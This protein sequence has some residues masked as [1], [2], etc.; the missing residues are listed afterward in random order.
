MRKTVVPK[1]NLSTFIYARNI[2]KSGAQGNEMNLVIGITARREPRF[3]TAQAK[4]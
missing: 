4:A 1:S 2:L 3:F